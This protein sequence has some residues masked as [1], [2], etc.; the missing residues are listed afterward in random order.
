HV[1]QSSEQLPTP[2]EQNHDVNL[3]QIDGAH[4]ETTI[5]L[6]QPTLRP[7][8]QS[9]LHEPPSRLSSPVGSGRS[10]VQEQ[11]SQAPE[12]LH[13]GSVPNLETTSV[14]QEAQS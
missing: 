10:Y 1:P 6:Q 8:D 9:P 5:V 3:L 12:L 7:R 4:L 14:P 13:T 2:A 11:V